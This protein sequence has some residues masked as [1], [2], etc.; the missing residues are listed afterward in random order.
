M[1]KLRFIKFVIGF[2]ILTC[3]VAFSQD[4][5][6]TGIQLWTDDKRSMVQI[7]C[8]PVGDESKN[9]DCRTITT[10]YF[11]N[12][13]REEL[14]KYLANNPDREFFDK[15]GKIKD[16]KEFAQLCSK[17]VVGM[18]KFALGFDVDHQDMGVSIEDFKKFKT[19]FE[20]NIQ[21]LAEEEKEDKITGFKLML[22]FCENGDY[23]SFLDIGIHDH[24]IREKTCSIGVQTHSFIYK[25]IKDGLF[26]YER[27]PDASDCA[28]I[29]VDTIRRAGPNYWDWEFEFKT[30]SLNPEG[31]TIA[32]SVC[33]EADGKPDIYKSIIGAGKVHNGCS[34]F[35]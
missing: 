15:S 18:S 9:I 20:T 13:K 10:I 12:A 14:K 3:G 24:K 19:E 21:K 7:N 33:K 23:Q 31:K 34:Y 28:K 8:M 26:V 16:Q 22:N 2:L 32:G 11:P 1:Q 6:P 30:I 29:L 25:K 5:F 27:G 17:Q 4:D 35:E